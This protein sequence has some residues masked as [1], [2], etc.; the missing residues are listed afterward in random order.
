[1]ARAVLFD[2]FETLITESRTR[3]AGVASLA[4]ALGCEREAFRREWRALRPAVTRGEVTFRQALANIATRLEGHAGEATLHRLCD[5]RVRVK[6]VPFAEVEPEILSLVDQLRRCGVRLGMVSNCFAE[7]V[8]AWLA[9][10]LSSRFECAVYSFDVGLAKPDPA[11]YREATRRLGV[12][13]SDTWFVG[14]GQNE[15][16]AGAA[17]AGVHAL[18][19]DWFLKR[20]PHYREEPPSGALAGTPGEVLDLLGARSATAG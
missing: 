19:A 14:D 17:R 11:I 12:E 7:D 4:P 9:C 10:P 3:P 16:L 1:M 6:A 20:W 18:K 15:E 13:P 8:T 2:L 5:E